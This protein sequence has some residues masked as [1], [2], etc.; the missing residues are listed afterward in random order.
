[1]V[2]VL[3]GDYLE[4]SIQPSE[5]WSVLD[6]GCGCGNNLIPFIDLGA[7]CFGVE[8]EQGAVDVANK[9][10]DREGYSANIEI[11][12]NRELPYPDN[13]FDLLISVN[14]LH[15]ETNEEDYKAGLEEY[16]RVLKEDGILFI[17][18]L[19]SKTE[20]YQHAKVVSPHVFERREIDFRD[21][22][23]MFY[24]SNEKYLK[25]YLS[26]YFAKTETGRSTSEL[27][28]KTRDYLLAVSQAPLTD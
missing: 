22:W 1:M 5:D 20:A 26:D 25:S 17:E 21:G 9:V 2:R 14:V 23:K 3:F 24:V 28:T 27:M 11:G 18:T 13:K 12:E 7:D 16:A 8:P 10:L 19:G 6:V 15:Y 4:D